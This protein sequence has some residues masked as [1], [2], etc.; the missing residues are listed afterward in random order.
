MKDE[1]ISSS[2]L[3]AGRQRPQDSFLRDWK[4]DFKN[5][6]REHRIP[7]R[8]AYTEDR[9]TPDNILGL[10]TSLTGTMCTTFSCSVTRGLPPETIAT[11]RKATSKTPGGYGSND[12]RRKSSAMPMPPRHERHSWRGDNC[13]KEKIK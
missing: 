1:S 8:N 6:L 5:L 13:P 3:R 12:D 4:D 11:A 7:I 10:K 2:R 9:L